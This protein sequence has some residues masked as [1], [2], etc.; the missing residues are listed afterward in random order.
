MNQVTGRV[1]EPEDLLPGKIIKVYNHEFEMLDM[2]EYTAKMMVDPNVRTSTFD[3]VAIVEKMR[4]SMRQQFPLVRDIFRRF[5]KDHDGVMTMDEFKKALEKFGFMLDTSEVLTIMKHFDKRQDGQIS[6]NEF[7]DTLLDED[8]T[9]EMMKLKPPLQPAFDRDYAEKAVMKK[10]ERGETTS[11]RNA[12]RAI[13]DVLY[14]RVGMMTRLFKE[15]SY[16]THLPT[17]SCEQIQYALLQLG[18][19]F[20]I[21]DVQRAVLFITPD[22][23]LNCIVYV[24]FF[25]ALQSAYHDLSCIR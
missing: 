15:F 24:D 5:D 12:V 14:K 6:Y 11:V 22:A 2:D 21:E 23:D 25:K 18:H 4:E 16:L 8:Y 19:S 10:T 3:M 20:D 7:C 9:T 1:F 17:V 13:G